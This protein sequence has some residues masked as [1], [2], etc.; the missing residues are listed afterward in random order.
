ML[1]RRNSLVSVE[2]GQMEQVILLVLV[3]WHCFDLT[4][5]IVRMDLGGLERSVR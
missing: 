4:A 3:L 2:H 1:R 5:M